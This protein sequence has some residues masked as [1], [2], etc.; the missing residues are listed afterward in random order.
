MARI[1]IM[2][3]AATQKEKKTPRRK[4]KRKKTRNET[5]YYVMEITD[6]DWSF[7][8]GVSPR[9][10]MDGPYSDYRHL[11]LRGRLL[12]PTRIKADE[13]KLSLLPDHRLNEDQRKGHE[14]QSVGSLQLYRGQLDGIV[15]IPADALGQVLQ[16]M[17]AG[18]WK[19]AVFDGDRLHYGQG[20]L[21]MFRLHATLEPDD[22]P[23]E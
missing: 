21:R 12:R 19:Y 16:M 5:V 22:L 13:V 3:T 10:D 4:T 15:S 9:R 20:R 2:E 6:W 7:M 14:P 17:I 18:R 23:P 11:D 8:F 1:I